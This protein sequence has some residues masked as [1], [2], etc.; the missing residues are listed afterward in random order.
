MSKPFTDLL[1]WNKYCKCCSIFHDITHLAV[2]ILKFPNYWSCMF[3][4]HPWPR[5]QA[6]AV[7]FC[8][9]G[10]MG[11][12]L[13][14]FATLI[15]LISCSASYRQKEHQFWPALIT[16]YTSLFQSQVGKTCLYS[17]Y[18]WISG[19]ERENKLK[20]ELDFLPY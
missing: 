16:S 7:V 3:A 6:L 13:C 1:N 9:C 10:H 8:S 5:L 2:Q 20:T 11:P 18:N 15:W 14:S 4:H 17:K 12:E 19:P